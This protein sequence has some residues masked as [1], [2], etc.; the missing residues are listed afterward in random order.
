MAAIIISLL[1]ALIN[2]YLAGIAFIVF[3][4]LIMSLAIMQ[5]AR[6]R[7]DVWASLADDAKGVILSNRGTAPAV[8][9]HT[10]LV[11]LNIEFDLPELEVDT[12]SNHELHEMIQNIKAVMTW[13]STEGEHYSRTVNLSAFGSGDDDLLKPM[14]P[15]FGWK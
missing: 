7:P 12:R 9:I 14:F 10:A 6:P 11:P 5:D 3:M 2:I 15:M 8:R 1:L 13:E 4:V